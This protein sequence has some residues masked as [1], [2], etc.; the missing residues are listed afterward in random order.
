[1]LAAALPVSLLPLASSAPVDEAPVPLVEEIDAQ[2]IALMTMRA[3]APSPPTPRYLAWPGTDPVTSE[4][5][6]RWGRQHNGVDIDG[7]IGDPITAAAD[8]VVVDADY[9]GGYGLM[10]IIRHT[11][12]FVG[13]TTAYAHLSSAA[14]APG[15]L[16]TRGELIG[17]MG[18]SG[19]AVG[20][21]L[22][23]EVRRGETP[24]DPRRFLA[25]GR[26]LAP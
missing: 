20:D 25:P 11:K 13:L 3:V 26:P 6:P 19:N 23:F 2:E 18:V 1:M 10:V 8:G 9:E 5:G 12:P 21:H 7:H 17:A 4:F 24:V 16:V 15:D 14:V 22:H